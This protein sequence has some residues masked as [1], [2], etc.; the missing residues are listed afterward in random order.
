MLVG[1]LHTGRYERCS[2]HAHDLRFPRCNSGTKL[3]LLPA[4]PILEALEGSRVPDGFNSNRGS[5]A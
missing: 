2:I 1:R 3:P 5:E 4:F